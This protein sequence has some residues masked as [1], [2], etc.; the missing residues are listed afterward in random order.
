MDKFLGKWR[1]KKLIPVEKRQ[2][3]SIPIYMEELE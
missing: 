1:L 2:I 3:L